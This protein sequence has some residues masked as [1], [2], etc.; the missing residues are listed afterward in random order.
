[1]SDGLA[2]FR[3]VAEV[4]CLHQPVIVKGRHPN[5][6]T[7][8][9]WINTVLSN[10]KTSFNGT[11]DAL[12]FDKY[13]DRYLDAFSYRF[14]RSFDLATMTERVLLAACLCIAQP[15][16]LHGLLEVILRTSPRLVPATP[17]A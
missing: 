3:A 6:L 7:E 12:R 2:C 16:R 4:G 5:E 17:A 10:L 14:N 9:R 15:E 11:F 1:M 13:S 8:F